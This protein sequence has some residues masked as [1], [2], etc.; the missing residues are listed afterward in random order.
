MREI[1]RWVLTSER[2]P[3]K[4]GYYTVAGAKSVKKKQYYWNGE[5]W[6]TPGHCPATGIYSWM[7]VDW[8]DD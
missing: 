5:Y 1:I 4:R 6:V 8:D 7:E 2:Q 3:A